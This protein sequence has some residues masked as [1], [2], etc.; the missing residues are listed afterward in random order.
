[1]LGLAAPWGGRNFLPALPE[2]GSQRGERLAPFGGFYRV[3]NGPEV[4]FVLIGTGP[5]PCRTP[6][7]HEGGAGALSSPHPAL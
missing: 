2:L 1:M 5:L 6:L 3:G 4:S 7:A